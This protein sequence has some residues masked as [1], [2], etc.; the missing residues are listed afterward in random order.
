[1][2]IFRVNYV[3]FFLLSLNKLAI[4]L[5]SNRLDPSID[6]IGWH[7]SAEWA[8]VRSKSILTVTSS[9]EQRLGEVACPA[10]HRVES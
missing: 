10:P 1:M 8:R 2:E 9:P 3:S 7:L 6:E 4:D 5:I